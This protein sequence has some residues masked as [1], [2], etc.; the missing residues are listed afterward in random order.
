[1]TSTI[2][3]GIDYTLYNFDKAYLYHGSIN[4]AKDII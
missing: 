2:T 3:I 4:M 1:M